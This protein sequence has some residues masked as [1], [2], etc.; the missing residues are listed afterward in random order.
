VDVGYSAPG[1]SLTEQNIRYV[2]AMVQQAMGYS[3]FGYFLFFNEEDAAKLMDDHVR[4][5]SCSLE[6]M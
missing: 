3:V 1:W 5:H 2:N 4:H 6:K